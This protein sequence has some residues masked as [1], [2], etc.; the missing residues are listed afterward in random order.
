MTVL[1]NI[2]PAT[3]PFETRQYLDKAPPTK[4]PTKRN[5]NQK[6]HTYINST[7]FPINTN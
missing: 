3:Q 5:K 2:K 6:Q 1:K 4:K 7:T